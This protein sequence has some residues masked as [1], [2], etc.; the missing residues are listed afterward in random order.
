MLSKTYPGTSTQQN[1]TCTVTHLLSH[2]PMKASMTGWSLL[3]KCERAHLRRSPMDHWTWTHYCA[4]YGCC[5]EVWQGRM[6]RENQRNSYCQHAMMMM[7]VEILN[8]CILISISTIL[9]ILSVV[10]RRTNHYHHDHQGN[11]AAR[12]PFI[13][14]CHPS[15]FGIVLSK[16]YLD[17]L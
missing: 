9:K 8:K 13:L 10:H 1:N 7:I 16:T 3:K 6:T 14:S 11:P 4:K 15:L 2:K 12:V 17:G 5:Q